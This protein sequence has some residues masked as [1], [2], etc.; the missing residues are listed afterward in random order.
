MVRLISRSLFIGVMLIALT[1][2][3]HHGHAD[4]S[5]DQIEGICYACQIQASGH[6]QLA[7]VSE[8]LWAFQIP[9]APA[10]ADSVFVTSIAEDLPAIRPPPVI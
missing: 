1:G 10:I 2:V 7:S 9:E 8:T 3:L 4:S 5:T 6:W